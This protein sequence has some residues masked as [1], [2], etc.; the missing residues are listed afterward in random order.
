MRLLLVMQKKKY[1]EPLEPVLFWG[2]IPRAFSGFLWMQSFFKR[3]KSPLPK[4]VQALIRVRVSQLLHCPFCID[5]NMSAAYQAGLTQEKM[6]AMADYKESALYT[7]HEKEVLDYAHA[8]VRSEKERCR[9]LFKG[10]QN[11]FSDDA[12]IELTALVSYQA[13]SAL[14]NAALGIEPQ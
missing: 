5:M 9:Q 14:F 10:L 2:R 6:G 12:L 3:R 4:S 13:M 1:G 7:P 11:T 8:V